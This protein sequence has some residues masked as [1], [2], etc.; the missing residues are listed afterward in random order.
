MGNDQSR[1]GNGLGGKKGI[2]VVRDGTVIKTQD[3]EDDPDMKRLKEM[4]KFLPILRAGP[5]SFPFGRKDLC[6]HRAISPHP[7]LQLSLRLSNHFALC[8]KAVTTKQSK[9]SGGMKRM[10]ER[11]VKMVTEITERKKRLERLCEALEKVKHMNEELE[12]MNDTFGAITASLDDLSLLL[13]SDIHVPP[14]TIT[15]PLPPSSMDSSPSTSSPSPFPSSSSSST[16]SRNPSLRDSPHRLP[17]IHEV[18]V[19]DKPPSQSKR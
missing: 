18:R 19:I 5:G 3:P 4:P 17:P 10:E 12:K 6:Q 11:L 1:G 14:F 7:F 9:L 13:P 2:V 15:P 16:P 8:A